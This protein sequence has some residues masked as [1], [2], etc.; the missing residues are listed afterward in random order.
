MNRNILRGVLSLVLV[1]G[2]AACGG[3]AS[4]QMDTGPGDDGAVDTGVDVPDAGADIPGTDPGDRDFTPIDAPPE[5]GAFGAP[6]NDNVECDSGFCIEGPEGFFCT[7]ICVQNCPEGFSCRTFAAAGDVVS[8]CVPNF[9]KGCAA[10]KADSQ[11][12]GGRCVQHEGGGHCFAPCEADDTCADDRFAC[13]EKTVGEAVEKLCMPKTDSCSCLDATQEGDVRTCAVSNHFGTCYGIETCDATTGWQGCNAATPA[14]ETCDGLDQNC[15]GRVDEDLPETR[16][17]QVTVEDIG[18]CDGLERCVGALGWVCDAATPVVETCDYLDNDC[19]GTVDDGF[20][21]GGVYGDAAHCGGCGRSCVGVLPN[22]VEACDAAGPEDPHCVVAECDPGYIQVGE[23]QC[24][25]LQS[26]LCLP[27]DEDADCATGHCVPLDDASYCTVPCN[28]NV[29]PEGYACVTVGEGTFMVPESGAC[30]CTPATAGQTRPCFRTGEAGTCYGFETCDPDAGWLGCTATQPAFEA[31]NGLDD[32]CD[33]IVDD[34]VAAGDPCTVAVPDV[35][36]CSGVEVCRGSLG[37]VCTASTPAPET[38]NYLDDDCNEVVDDGFL[39]D[40]L[41]VTDANC[42]VCGNDCARAIPNGTGRCAVVGDAAR[43]VVDFCEPGFQDIG[44]F[45]CLEAPDVVCSPC[46]DDAQCLGGL[47]L[48]IGDGDFCTRD[49]DVDHPCPDGTEC[50]A[51]GD[52]LRCLPV[53]G[54]CDC[55]AEL[56]GEVRL[57]RATS[58]F[59]TCYGT[60]TCNPDLGGW[61]GCDAATAV[62]ETCNGLDDDCDGLVDDGVEAT[63]PC[64]IGN[65]FGTCAG[66]AVCTAS[67]YACNAPTPAEDVCDFL[68]NDCDGATDEDFVTVDPISGGV[69]Y[70]DVAHCGTCG[71]DCGPQILNGTARCDASLGFPRCV[72]AQCDDGFYQLNDYQ[73]ILAPDVTCRPCDT[74]EQCFGGVCGVL[75]GRGYCL[76]PCGGEAGQCD[77]G[78]LCQELPDGRSGCV[79]ATGT[80]DCDAGSAGARRACSR[81]NGFGTCLGFQT[82]DALAG[83]SDCDAAVPSPELCDGIDNDCN[84]Q[85]DDALPASTPCESS[86]AFGTCTGEAFCY[87]KLGWICQADT[88]KAEVC[89][90]QD[91]DCDGVIDG[92]FVDGEGR[93]VDF[94]NCGSCG[95]SCAQG[96]PNAVTACDAGDA[97]PMCKVQSC[98]PGYFKLNDFQC[99]PNVAKL[100]EP[101]VIDANCIVEGARCVPLGDEGSFCGLPCEVQADCDSKIQGYVCT[102]FGAFKQCLPATGSCSCDGTNPG[103]QTGCSVAYQPAE[104]PA[105]MCYGTETCTPGGWSGCVLPE[106]SCNLLD[107]D[108]DG[109]TDEG[110]V[111]PDGGYRSDENC[112]ACG[113]DCTLLLFGNAFGVCNATVDPVRC[114]PQCEEGYFD[115]DS[116]PNDCECHKL[117]DDDWPGVDFPAF[118]NDLDVNCDGVDGNV[119]K[120]IFVAKNGDD[121]WPG[122]RSEPKRTIQ[123]GI[124]TAFL[125]GKRDVY[126]ASG[127]Y[128]EAV[129]L[130]VGVGVYG[131]YSADFR[132]RDMARY[133]SAVLAPAPVVGLPGAVNGI[134][135]QGGLPGTTVLDGFTVFA[136]E[137]RR[138]GMS[139]YG[140]YLHECDVTVRVS[141]NILV[142]GSGGPGGRGIDGRDGDDGMGGTPGTDATDLLAAFGIDHCTTKTQHVSAGGAAGVFQCG[143]VDVSGGAGGDRT[144]P[145]LVSGT[146]DQTEAPVPQEYGAAG[147]NNGG[148]GGL[149][150]APGRDVFH[151]SYSCDGYTSLGQI[152]GDNGEDGREGTNGGSGDGCLD[153][154][155]AVTGGMWIPKLAVDGTTGFPGGGG[156]GGGS[157]GGAWSHTS[158][159][160]KGFG[161]DNFGGT[162]G[163][164]GS[165]GCQGTAGTAGTG[166]GGA[167]TVFVVFDTPPT[168][169]PWIEANDLAGGVGGA[170]GAGGNGGVGGSGG[171]GALGGKEGGGYVPPSP[172]YPAFQGGKGGSG[173]RG[174]HGGGGGGGCGG[175]AYGIFVAGAGGADLS[176]WKAGNQFTAPGTGGTGGTGGFSLGNPGGDGADGIAADTNF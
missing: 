117:A 163:G 31:C 103:L 72:V 136:H 87:G 130:A 146:N 121:A 38:C 115:L 32:D 6:C 175:P 168:T 96:F 125:Q 174:G 90:Y 23:T 18:T 24:F 97:L 37:L 69:R 104:G 120:A 36:V 52:G 128:R 12:N 20:Q 34:G 67:G 1:A 14:E 11:C 135:I 85:I 63:R 58:T 133:E 158:C 166:A 9:T 3:G 152:E 123:A 43:C 44:G 81:T 172:T 16:P 169:T 61:G 127:V 21:V 48:T 138:P 94:A 83:W 107:D 2:I 116:N 40:G 62:E 142:G 19:N 119:A 124:D 78:L 118:P 17:C 76:A 50:Q 141:N 112:G 126:V 111:D 41:Y 151:Q 47:C 65:A 8:L 122:T 92:P 114:G 99:I 134:G 55:T 153:A 59:G 64:A 35:G 39:V 150:G 164:G 54:S 57:C 159:F 56:A 167:F 25:G 68:D 74:D 29:P 27:C 145:Q 140:V 79:P 101:C 46:T 45:L 88:P 170:G 49:C 98:D 51:V 82:C 100:C 157:G 160:S 22:A 154:D 147:L 4:V 53:T 162:G 15:N 155:G 129:R 132:V 33:G 60:E 26:V 70:T 86:N 176:A 91:N 105:Y 73:C 109:M 10:C 171:F 173:G 75:D 89:D 106:E 80:C 156:G 131:G 110:F 28:G 144:C 137:E 161:W 165:G 5:P 7:T 102:D 148:A 42:G 66:I 13:V 30:G 84:G 143:A 149:G 113:N 108:C 139:S 71:N 95:V 77:A 93:Y